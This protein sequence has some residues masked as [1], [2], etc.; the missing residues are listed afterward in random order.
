MIKRENLVFIR[1]L[2]YKVDD[3][4]LDELEIIHISTLANTPQVQFKAHQ[5]LDQVIC[6][7]HLPIYNIEE[8]DEYNGYLISQILFNAAFVNGN[9]KY[10]DHFGFG[11][12]RRLC[13]EINMLA[14]L[15]SVSHLLWCFRIE[16]A[17][18]LGK[19]CK[20]VP[21]HMEMIRFGS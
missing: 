9:Y 17:P 19:D 15:L 21:I 2:L 10:R 16:N 5:E 13:T 18:P 3:G 8:D 20:P 7:S 11:A 4:V 6:Q 1:D 12:G 14:L